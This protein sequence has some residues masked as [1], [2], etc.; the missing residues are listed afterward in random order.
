MIYFET[1]L[2]YHL[3][4]AE[5]KFFSRVAEHLYKFA[6]ESM[7][8]TYESL[9]VLFKDNSQ[10]NWNELSFASMSTAF[11][12][13]CLLLSFSSFVFV[14]EIVFFYINCLIFIFILF[15]AISVTTV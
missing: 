13:I 11:K 14:S 1:G 2:H 7:P 5:S 12:L 15:S 9:N 4:D 3:S 6:E 8:E 10:E